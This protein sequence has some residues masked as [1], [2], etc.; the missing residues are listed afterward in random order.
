M[1]VAGGFLTTA[2]IFS[3]LGGSFFVMK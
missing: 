3:V 2:I 1:A